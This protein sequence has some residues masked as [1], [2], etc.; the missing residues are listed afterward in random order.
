MVGSNAAIKLC[1]SEVIL[2]SPWW[3]TDL[4]ML[5]C[6]GILCQT[7]VIEVGFKLYYTCRVLLAI[8]RSLGVAAQRSDLRK[9]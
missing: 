4:P 5:A 1:F 2:T 7:V 9:S 6:M 3:R 8:V